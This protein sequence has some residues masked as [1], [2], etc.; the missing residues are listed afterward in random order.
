MNI[1]II[2]L[3]ITNILVPIIVAYIGLQATRR[4]KKEIELL[5]IT[6]K[7]EI[8]KLEIQYN[9]QLDLIKKQGGMNISESLTDKLF[10]EVL[11]NPDVKKAIHQGASASVK[12]GRGRNR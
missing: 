1:E 8:E 2:I 7:N 11:S 12:K 3:I 10:D 9:H 4:Y 5:K 6:H